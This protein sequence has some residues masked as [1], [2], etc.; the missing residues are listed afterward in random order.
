M[1]PGD[2]INCGHSRPGHNIP[3][4]GSRVDLFAHIP[5]TPL[6]QPCPCANPE[7]VGSLDFRPKPIEPEPI[8]IEWTFVPNGRGGNI[9]SLRMCS[10]CAAAVGVS[11]L[12]V[13]T[14]WHRALEG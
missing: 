12:D 2:C 11:V 9:P 3:V 4:C 8:A 14:E 1:R 7:F 6:Q 13:H 10:I 5:G